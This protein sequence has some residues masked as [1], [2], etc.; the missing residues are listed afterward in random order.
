M[1]QPRSLFFPV[2]LVIVGVV[3]LAS[4]MKVVPA[5]GWDILAQWWPVLLVLSG[6]NSLYM[7]Q[8]VVG[9]LV[10]TGL[11]VVL[12][13]GNLGYLQVSALETLWRFWPV[14]L[15]A[16]GIEL[17]FGRQ[18]SAWALIVRILLAVVLIAGIV[19][20][21][22]AGGA[23]TTLPAHEL[24]LPAAGTKQ[25]DITLEPVAGKLAVQAGDS[26]LAVDGKLYLST[27]EQAVTSAE[28]TNGIGVVNASATGMLMGVGDPGWV[29]N[30]KPGLPA[31]LT[32]EMAFGS[33]E[34]DL[35]D[36]AVSNLTLDNA[37]GI[38]T[39]M[40]GSHP[41]SAEI[42]SA[43]AD[44]VVYVPQGVAVQVDLDTAVTVVE[45]PPDYLRNGDRLTAPTTGAPIIQL[46]IS[47]AVGRVKIAYLP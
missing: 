27:G 43:V 28:V 19:W 39:I 26:D 5:S 22:M 9:P 47:N 2:L 12:L 17:L 45:Y 36:L 38:N 25:V 13:L 15:I 11:G 44:V 42:D 29:V 20:L 18:R 24:T 3:L 14:L 4:N 8:G 1:K 21:A 10:L 23:N 33:M 35:R 40:L 46:R 37:V 6:L 34:L 31:T 30:I 7:R 16:A 32:A 41:I